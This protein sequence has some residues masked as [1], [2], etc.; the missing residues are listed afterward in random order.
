MTFWVAQVQNNKRP[1][2]STAR[3][4]GLISCPFGTNIEAYGVLIFDDFI[5]WTLP[6]ICDKK[7]GYYNT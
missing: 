4:K 3:S 1:T 5:A 2:V 6:S 7:S